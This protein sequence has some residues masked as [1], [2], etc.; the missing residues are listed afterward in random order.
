MPKMKWFSYLLNSASVC[1]ILVVSSTFH[2]GPLTCFTIDLIW[3]YVSYRQ[4]VGLLGRVISPVTRPGPTRQTPKKCGQTFM[5]QVG[6]ELTILM[7][8]QAETFLALN[9]V[10]AVICLVAGRWINILWFEILLRMLILL[11]CCYMILLT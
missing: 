3:N 10:T 6:V 7:F 4:L 5:P 2:I 11:L 8:E 9:R 1:R